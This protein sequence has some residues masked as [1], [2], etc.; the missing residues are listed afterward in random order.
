MLS[1]MVVDYAE[2]LALAMK[3]AQVDARTL[4]NAL[5]ISYQAVKKVLDGRSNALTAYNTTKAAQ[6]TATN[7]VWLATG[8]GP[9]ALPAEIWEQL[10]GRRA[11]VPA[12]PA[13]VMDLGAKQRVETAERMMRIPFEN[14]KSLKELSRS[15]AKKTK[16]RP[17]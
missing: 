14:P 2:R 15:A 10:L 7:P 8:E 3:H 6:H 9:M 5:S 11:I 12:P 17:R 1:T 4:A 16:R 13:N